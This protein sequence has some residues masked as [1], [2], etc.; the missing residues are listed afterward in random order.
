MAITTRA[1]KGSPLTHT[2][3]DTN[4]TDLRDNKAGYVTGD[5]GAVTQSTSKST[6]VTLSKKCGQ[7]TLN[8]AALAADTT[9]SFTLTNTTVAATDIIVLNHVSGGT[10]GSY[11]LNAQAA[12]GSASI[13]VRNI[14]S[15]SLSEA[16]VIGFAVVKA[17]IA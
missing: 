6:G 10:A 15:G 11:L 5:G 2:E 4:F 14:T 7:I 9:V 1:T 3:V 8:G 12:A 16:I 13:N 17:V